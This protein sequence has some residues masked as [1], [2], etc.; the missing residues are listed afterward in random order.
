MMMVAMAFSALISRLRENLARSVL[1]RV[2][3]AWAQLTAMHSYSWIVLTTNLPQRERHEA[4][5]KPLLTRRVRPYYRTGPM[6][7]LDYSA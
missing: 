5:S 1:C 6:N 4:R 3:T 7:R 2:K